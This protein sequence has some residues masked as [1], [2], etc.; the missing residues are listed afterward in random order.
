MRRCETKKEKGK[1]LERKWK[2]HTVNDKDVGYCM[3]GRDRKFGVYSLTGLLFILAYFQPP[4]STHFD[5]M[6]T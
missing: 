3:N 2:M 5:K 1:L 4:S 6:S